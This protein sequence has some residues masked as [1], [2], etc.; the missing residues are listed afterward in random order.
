MSRNCFYNVAFFFY[1]FFL[2][3]I[4][5]GQAGQWTW[6]NGN[7]TPNDTGYHGILGVPSPLNK[8]PAMFEPCQW[9][10]L[11]GNFWMYG[12]F[13]LPVYFLNDLWKYDPLTNEWTWMSGTNTPNDPGSYGVQG[14]PSALNHPPSRALGAASWIDRNGN[15]WFF[16]GRSYDWTYCDL[17][18]Y[19]ISTNEWTWMKGAD[20]T[21]LNGTYGIKGTPDINNNPGSRQFINRAWTDNAGD[22]WFFGGFLDSSSYNDL[23]RFNIASNTWTWMKGTPLKGQSSIY[24]T[25]GVEDSTNTPGG[26]SES[27]GWKDKLGNFWL[28]GGFQNE[29][30]NYILKSDLWRFNPVTNNWTWMNGSG[31]DN[32]NSIYGVK[33]ATSTLNLPGK[34]W[35]NHG[36]WTDPNGNF[37]M[38]GGAS[39]IPIETMWND[40]WMYCVSTNQWT[41]V[42]GDSLTDQFG[43]WGTLGIS[44][45]TNKPSSRAGS[46][47]WTNHNGDLYLF[48]G[49]ADPWLSTY[50]ND[51]WKYTIDPSCGISCSTIAPPVALF[52]SSDTA[53][54]ANDCID[55]INLSIYANSYQWFFP[56]ASRSSDTTSNP[57][58]ICYDSAGSYGVTLVAFN[59]NGSD[60]LTFSNY[61]I[62]HALP[63]APSITQVH[64]DT[65]YCSTDTSYVRYQWYFDNALIAGAT[66]TLLVVNKDGNYNVRISNKDSCIVGAGINVTL[67]VQDFSQVF[68]VL[69]NPNPSSGKFML[70]MNSNEHLPVDIFIYDAWGNQ[71]Y[72][73]IK[74]YISDLSID[75]SKNAKGVYLVKV[76]SE[77]KVSVSRVVFM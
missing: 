51:L 50:Y 65:L 24:G 47:G 71:I 45:P 34:R 16:G 27:C 52:Q 44:N 4:C 36:T 25:K 10:D 38:F 23:W 43:D 29:A 31:L 2:S 39:K 9:T 7:N 26:L 35:E 72:Q 49:C 22:L 11:N 76:V 73:N 37:W 46:V 21:I 60:T 40:L 59:N 15:F 55:L 18:K 74:T 1:L 48:G 62:V 13:S 75:L 17:W 67:A 41:W 63:S 28:F 70:S 14:I 77:G 42:S 12:G 8:P 54:C 58:G 33:C 20:S 61:I 57:K 53:F 19:D 64:N 3:Q 32:S 5:K 30:P 69:I 6:I 66:D 56:G 68:K